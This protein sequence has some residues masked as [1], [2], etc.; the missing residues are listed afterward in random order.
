MAYTKYSLTPANNNAAP[1]DGAPEGMLPSA[2]NDTMRD[3]MAQIR[4]V[5]DGIRGG[6]YTMTAP[7]ITGGSIT[8]VALSGN[9]FTNPVITGGSINNTTIGA[10]TASTGKFTALTNSALTSGRVTYAG[11]SGVLQDDADFTFNGT[12]VTMANDASISGLTV[13]KGS[14]SS[15]QNTTFGASALAA[16]TTGVSNVAIGYRSLFANTTGDDNTAVGSRRDGVNAGSLEKN[17]TGS[18]QVAI[19]G[20]SLSENTTGTQNTGVGYGSLQNNTT[21]SY[22]TAH[23][24]QALGSNTTASNNTAVGYQAAYSNTT[25]SPTDAFGYQALYSNTTGGYNQAF[26]GS[27]LRTNTTGFGNTA[28]GVVALYANTTG[29]SN[30]AIGTNDGVTGAALQNNTTGSYNTAIGVSAL[31][32]N[33]TASNNTAVGYQAGYSNTTGTKNLSVGYQAGYTVTTGGYNTLIGSGG[34]AASSSAGYS[35]TTANNNTFIGYSAGSAVTTGSNNTIIGA[36]GGNQGGLDIRTASNYIVLSDGDGNPRLVS[37]GSGNV[38]VGTTAAVSTEKLLAYQ[39]ANSK[40]FMSKAT[41]ASFSQQC[42]QAEVDRN[43]TN[44]SFSAFAYYNAGAGATRF[45]VLDSGNVQNT[46]NS[47]GAISDVK[48][49]ENIVDTSPKLEDLC[50]VKVRN[51]NLKSDQTHKQIG[52]IA[53]EL[54]EVFPNLI[55][56]FADK[57][58]EGNDLGTTTKAVKYSVFV[59]MLIKAVQEL[60][61]EVDSLK[62]QL[63]K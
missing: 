29:R 10:T 56:E 60:K 45:Q 13:G 17:T 50:K 2:V 42:I 61:A 19:G 63:G 27:A 20:A 26:G 59:P 49:K 34:A 48:L 3:M 38:F 51:Y 8:G 35:L 58:N 15:S 32:G 14:G 28:I 11:T 47:Y 16:N 24:T 31:L 52:V 62:Q 36:Y 22:N 23:G 55:E 12:T 7:V 57:D 46:N 25:G 9:T 53:Q 30:I 5:G 39:T 18:R 6:T 4:D 21:G 54:E 33:T 41:N 44:G 1:P 40:G 37:D 43:T